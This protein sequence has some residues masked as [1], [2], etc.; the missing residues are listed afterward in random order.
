MVVFHSFASVI[1]SIVTVLI[2]GVEP[3][4]NFS[5]GGGRDMK[6]ISADAER[7]RKFYRFS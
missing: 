4:G 7:E 1:P 5:M 6:P 3:E 2:S